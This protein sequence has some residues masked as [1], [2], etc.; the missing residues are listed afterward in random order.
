MWV[1]VSFSFAFHFLVILCTLQEFLLKLLVQNSQT[2]R[3]VLSLTSM[4]LCMCFDIIMIFHLNASL[5]ILLQIAAWL[6]LVSKKKLQKHLPTLNL[7]AVC[8]KQIFQNKKNAKKM[9]SR[10][11]DSSFSG[12]VIGNKD[13]FLGLRLLELSS[14]YSCELF[15]YSPLNSLVWDIHIVCTSK[16]VLVYILVFWFGHH[17]NQAMAWVYA[18]HRGLS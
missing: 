11:T 12:Y 7:A 8:K 5:V 18:W 16:D 4:L 3:H 9:F 1:I 14:H 17:I 6:I 15:W 13:F 10:P 2:A